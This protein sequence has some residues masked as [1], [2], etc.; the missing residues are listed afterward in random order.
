[1]YFIEP[2]ACGRPEQPPNSTMITTKGFE[3]GATVEYNC[4]EGHLLVG[5]NARTCL[6]T[7]F[8]NEFPPVCKYIECGL[9]ASIPHGQYDLV[10]GS[11]GYLSQVVYKCNEGYEMLGRAML[12]CDIDERW[13]GPPPR[14]EVIECDVLPAVYKNSKI[15]MPNGTFFGSK[16]EIQCARGFKLDGPSSI[17]CTSTGQWSAPVTNCVQDEILTTLSTPPVTPF[18]RTRTSIPPRR[19]PTSP[20]SRSST[21]YTTSTTTKKSIIPIVEVDESEEDISLPGQVR[22]E[23]PPR[24]TIRPV[25]LIPKNN[26]PPSATTT[27]ATTTSV[28]ST[29]N[30]IQSAHPQDNE[31]AGSVNIR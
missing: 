6:E 2:K 29:Q 9:P 24:K 1:M 14:C 17:T 16:A 25:V 22:E 18:T 10:N 7:G 23:F 28:K 15:I 5:P 19:Q 13:N 4:D 31:I 8:Y 3:V 30:I 26:Q 27:Q 12:T 21:K 11:V 20:P